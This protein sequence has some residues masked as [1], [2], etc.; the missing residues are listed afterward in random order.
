M[1]TKP[2]SE[3]N[4]AECCEAFNLKPESVEYPLSLQHIAEIDSPILDR[5][6]AL[7]AEQKKELDHC[8]TIA[9]LNAFVNRHPKTSY[10]AKARKKMEALMEKQKERRERCG[11]FGGAVLLIII[12]FAGLVGYNNYSERQEAEA[13]LRAEQEA[14]LSGNGRNGVYKVGDYYE[15]NGKQG[16]VFWVDS[17]GKHGKIVSTYGYS[18]S[19]S[20]ISTDDVW[21]GANSENDGAY[22]MRKIQAQLSW[23]S[24]YPAAAFCADLGSGWYLPANVELYEISRV[25][26][27]LNKTLEQ[28][29]RPTLGGRYWSSTE[30]NDYYAYTVLMVGAGEGD[31]DPKYDK[32]NVRAVSAF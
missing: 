25:M 6:N 7:L 28:K 8:A 4:F 9:D 18:R 26:E 12:V 3:L 10:A 27:K 29:N 21:I 15:Q 16:L 13:R 5:L 30:H 17:S 11:I 32:N 22:N 2:I 1:K 19:W 20:A 31:P 24:N 23:R 14:V